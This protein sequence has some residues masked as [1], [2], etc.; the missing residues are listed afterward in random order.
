MTNPT[1][2][3]PTIDQYIV[4][5]EQDTPSYPV[6]LTGKHNGIPM[7]LQRS[8]ALITLLFLSPLLMIVMLLI[9]L[10]SG[11]SCFFSQDRIGKYG[12]HFKMYKF[13][14]MYLKTDRRYAE[15]DPSTSDRD[16]ICKKYKND[17]RIS[18][19]GAFIRKFS[20]DELPQ[21]INIVKG[22]MALIGP[23]PALAIEVNAYPTSA[24]CRL[25]GMPG[26]SGLWQVSGR[27]DTDFDTQVALDDRYLQKQ[28]VGYDI[29]ILLATL[30]CV[31][32]AR[33]AY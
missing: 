12:R 16:G 6:K 18:I 29:R 25:N 26:L 20:I 2:S 33:G 9:R 24:L 21:L 19:V 30:P 28:S 1:I 32:G 7:F 17:P 31:I 3:N 14:S 5:S 8:A 11:G 10:E 15:P 27:A 22:D 4:S 23:R 13:R